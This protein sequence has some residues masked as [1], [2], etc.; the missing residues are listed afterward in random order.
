MLNNIRYKIGTILLKRASELIETGE[1]KKIMRG[2]KL[3]KLTVHIV[4]MSQE[5]VD[6]GQCMGEMAK[7][8]PNSKD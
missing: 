2:L 6:F 4:P 8:I 3:V 7:S 5:L 1:F